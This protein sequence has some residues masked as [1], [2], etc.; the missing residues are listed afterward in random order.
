M[1][2][3]TPSSSAGNFKINLESQ[4]S[5][6]QGQDQSMNIDLPGFGNCNVFYVDSQAESVQSPTQSLT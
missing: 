3:P 6:L 5:D 1:A 4:D 2:V